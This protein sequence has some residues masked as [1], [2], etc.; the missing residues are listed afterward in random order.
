MAHTWSHQQE[1]IFA[2]FAKDVNF[3]AGDPHHCYIDANGHLIV[4]ARAGTGKTT[5]I[6]EGANRAPEK[7]ILLCAY[8]KKI[9]EELQS[10]IKN[11]NCVAKTLHSVGYAAVRRFREKIQ[12]SFNDDRAN[13]LTDMVCG[14]H[15]PDTIKRLV[16][17]LHTKGREI[18]PHATMFGDLTTIAYEFDCIPDEQWESTFPLEYIEEKAL[19]AMELASQVKSG[20]TIDGSDM[21]FLPVRNGWLQKQYDLVIVD[22][23][24]DMTIAQ[25]EIA[26]GVCASRIAVVGDDRQAIYGFRGADSGSLDRLKRELGAAELGLTTTYR[27]AK[28]IVALAAGL[29]PDFEAGP[30][31]AEGSIEE[32]FPHELV[33]AAGPGDFILSRVNAPLVG[34]A[35][36]LLRAGK[37]AQVAGRDIGKGLVTLVRKFRANSVP[38][39]L[40]KVES[41]ETKEASRL[42]ILFD[43]A[44]N[45][46]KATLQA[47]MEAIHDQAEMLLSL[48]EGSKNVIEITDRIE[49][50]FTD[51]GLGA[52]G[53]I[54]LSSVHK[55]KGLEATKV[56]ILRETLRDYNQEEL[57]IRYVAITRSKTTLVWVSDRRDS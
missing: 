53:M 39:F 37:R 42:Q 50:L 16:S 5:T 11:P 18:A 47:K 7:R 51:D 35:M 13:K 23:A 52:T 54:T 21:I 9:A 49:N 48:A 27:C 44:A 1:D 29:V 46:R 43:K 2:W 30:N 33:A 3:F 25:L 19:E 20:E 28:S 17:K 6:I 15:A 34:T 10:R 36:K 40:R 32:I 31:N 22:E 26:Q 4:R 8:N 57:N 38:D 12:V 55:A 45:G 41:W 24:Q 14:N 56:F